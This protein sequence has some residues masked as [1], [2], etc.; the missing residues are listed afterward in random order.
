MI[1]FTETCHTDISAPLFQVNI[2]DLK[3][4]ALFFSESFKK[5]KAITIR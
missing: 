4:V 2:V 1:H 3:S 5:C